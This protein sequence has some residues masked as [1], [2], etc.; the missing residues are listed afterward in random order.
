MK[1]E[2]IIKQ[3]ALQETTIVINGY[4]PMVEKLVEAI[5]EAARRTDIYCEIK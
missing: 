2:L 3:G 4:Y 5:E 1:V